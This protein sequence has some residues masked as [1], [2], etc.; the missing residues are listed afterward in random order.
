M[1]TLP[2]H[3]FS[4]EAMA[5][6]FEVMIA[7]HE[8]RYASQVAN[9]VF[10]EIEHLEGLLSRFDARSDISQINRL[11]PG[12]SVRISLDALECLYL[13]AQVWRETGGAFDVTY[14]SPSGSGM[15]RLLL[16]MGSGS[17][18][19][20]ESG[21]PVQGLLEP[22]A[23]VCACEAGDTKGKVEIDLGAIGKGFALDRVIEVLTDW[24]V[25][26]ALLNAGTSTVLALDAPAGQQGWTVGVGGPW[27]A[28]VGFDTVPLRSMALS[29]SGYEIKGEHVVDPRT[30]RPPEWHQAAWAMCASAARSDALS[31]AFL[32]M[33]TEV[34]EGYCAD[35]PDVS[36]IVVRR[37]T[38]GGT[39]HR[40]GPWGL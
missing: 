25:R 37:D 15:K 30:G 24:E 21:V 8:E 12:Q 26:S 36:A 31:T 33:S 20:S 2:I 40:F 19:E 23:G 32:V 6:T 18:V 35:H 7:G 10:A 38:H 22:A 34:V 4:R 29:G 13:A 27:G 5:T 1:P 9:A 11:A 3:A 16:S 14:R 28:A 17:A 39:F